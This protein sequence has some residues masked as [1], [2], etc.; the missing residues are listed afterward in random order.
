ML[1]SLTIISG[2]TDDH[3]SNT[4]GKPKGDR[5]SVHEVA[6]RVSLCNHWLPGCA[7]PVSFSIS[8][9]SLDKQLFIGLVEI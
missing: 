5:S 6:Y 1:E 2:C 9:F 4:D 3:R 8:S 7:T